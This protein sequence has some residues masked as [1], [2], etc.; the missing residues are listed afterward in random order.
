MS[1][2]LLLFSSPV[3]GEINPV[4]PNAEGGVIVG[5]VMEASSCPDGVKVTQPGGE[6]ADD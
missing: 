5:R 2:S 1:Q 3:E 6:E 4:R